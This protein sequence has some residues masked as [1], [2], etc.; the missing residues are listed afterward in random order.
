MAVKGRF[1]SN[2]GII[3]SWSQIIVP[4]GATLA[5][6]DGCYIGRNVELGP[7]GTIRIGNRT[8]IQ[9]RCIILG[10]V[11]IGDHCVFAPNIFISSGR[12]HFDDTP[13]FLIKDQDEQA[14]FLTDVDSLA[15]RKVVIEDDCWIGVN[16]VVMSGVRISKG[17]VIGANA[18]VT[19]DV[20]PYAVV[21]GAPA[22]E[23]RKRLNFQPPKAVRW[24]VDE[25]MPY[26]YS[27]FQVSLMQRSRNTVMGG[28]VVQHDSCCLALAARAGE[29]LV[30]SVRLSRL[31]SKVYLRSNGV[32]HLLSADFC[33]LIFPILDHSA[34]HV[35]EVVGMLPSSEAY[36]VLQSARCI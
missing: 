18:V 4:D 17:A 9:D 34:L 29:R 24:D 16:A 20:A 30:V 26:F 19:K 15:G 28:L 12:H 35:L 32:C 6:G 8:S 21:A 1:I 25:H 27:G 23:L 22:R 33:D 31:T 10:N 36:V 3:N 13:W 14:A 5:L 2:G 11:H 7:V